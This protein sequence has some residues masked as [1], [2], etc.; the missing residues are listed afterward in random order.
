M[1]VLVRHHT[2]KDPGVAIED[3]WNEVA[4]P[5]PQGKIGLG[6]RSIVVTAGLEQSSDRNPVEIAL[7]VGSDPVWRW[8][9]VERRH[10]K[11]RA[12]PIFA[13]RTEP[14]P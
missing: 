2:V 12:E 11:Y 7:V 1:T 4:V 14:R 6:P 5:V 3:E 10:E 13:V 8:P 9:S